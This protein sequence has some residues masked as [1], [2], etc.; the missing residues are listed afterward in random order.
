VPRPAATA[1]AAAARVML[2]LR[3]TALSLVPGI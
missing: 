1:I 2:R 3:V